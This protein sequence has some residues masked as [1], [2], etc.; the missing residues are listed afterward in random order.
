MR[1]SILFLATLIL[2][3]SAAVAADCI[4]NRIC[5]A[6]TGEWVLMTDVSGEESGEQTKV[7]LTA[8]GAE[9]FTVKREHIAADGT[10]AETIDTTITL[11]DYNRRMNEMAARAKSVT[12]EFVVIGDTEYPVVAVHILSDK[13]D[14]NGNP[15][16][17][18]VWIS[19]KLPIGG[20][21]KTW[22]SDPAF[23]SAEVVDFGF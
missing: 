18:K 6:K 16:E 14:A 21:A 4:P 10:V 2:S 7:T 5:L 23:P 12:D 9:S 22:S 13:P 3:A 19:D 11:A 15:R 1:K 20:I 17:F 8:V